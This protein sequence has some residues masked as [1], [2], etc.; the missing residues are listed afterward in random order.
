[1]NGF[2]RRRPRSPLLLCLELRDPV[3][4]EGLGGTAG[5]PGW[6]PN[7]AGL[8]SYAREAGWVV[9]H[10]LSG[11]PSDSAL[12]RAPPELRP[13]PAEAV[14]YAHSQDPFANVA[15]V[16]FLARNGRGE[17]VFIGNSIGGACLTAT[18]SLLLQGHPVTVARDSLCASPK[19]WGG[20]N[21]LEGLP[22]LPS[23]AGF[24]AE[25]THA[26][27]SSHPRLRLI[28]GGRG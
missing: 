2:A 18:L 14:F 24:R 23:D 4:A 11:R 21:A 13:I 1:M 28:S 20:L 12:W 9:A 17:V 6:R 10:L 3:V 25:Y 26:V 8:L 22:R 27:I 16:Q 7:A 19:E 5:P 15:L